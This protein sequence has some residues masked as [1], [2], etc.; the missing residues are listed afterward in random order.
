MGEAAQC[1]GLNIRREKGKFTINVNQQQYIEELV[2]KFKMEQDKPL[3]TPMDPNQK[4]T[5]P[6]QIGAEE[7]MPQYP[8]AVSSRLFN[9][10][11][12]QY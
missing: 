8:L 5:K 10:P 6:E 1:L 12:C 7:N 11:I 4:S 3:V 2:E 9:I